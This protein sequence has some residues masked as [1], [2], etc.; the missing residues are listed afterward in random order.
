MA[1]QL[2]QS[3]DEDDILRPLR[4]LPT[5]EN[6][7]DPL[8][9]AFASEFQ[10][11]IPTK[12][13]Q[14][15]VSILRKSTHAPS[16]DVPSHWPLSPSSPSRN[17]EEAT[18]RNSVTFAPY[19]ITA[20]NFRPRTHILDKATLY[21]SSVDVGRFKREYKRLVRAAMERQRIRDCGDDESASS[22]GAEGHSSPRAQHDNSFW[23]SKVGQRRWTVPPTAEQQEQP[24][25][26]IV[27]SIPRSSGSES[28][29]SFWDPLNDGTSV[30]SSSAQEEECTPTSSEWNTSS[31]TGGIFSSAFD[32]AREAVSY[33]STAM[34]TTMDTATQSPSL[35]AT[36]NS[37]PK[38]RVRRL[39]ITSRNALVDTLY[40]F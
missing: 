3:L 38:R 31:F 39:S 19:L 20:T 32:V 11:S 9:A 4:Q 15:P 2:E 5:K 30:V 29:N 10:K 34:T 18:P 14:T 16:T 25:P 6:Q 36:T 26:S 33:Y 7:D 40:L 37:S 1:P 22:S 21:Y 27:E 35:P 24:P 17:Q 28:D 8:T 13:K 12:T 23:R